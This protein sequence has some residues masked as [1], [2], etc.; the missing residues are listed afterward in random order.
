MSLLKQDTGHWTE[1]FVILF[2]GN[3]PKEILNV[4]MQ[5]NYRRDETERQG[6]YGQN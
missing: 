2:D 5:K 6:T 3:Q 4:T 1:D